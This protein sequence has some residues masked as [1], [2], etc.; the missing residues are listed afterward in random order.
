MSASGKSNITS[1][2]GCID[3]QAKLLVSATKHS[4][5]TNVVVEDGEVYDVELVQIDVSKNID[6]FYNIQLV[7]HEEPGHADEF[8]VFCK[9]GRTGITLTN[10]F[11][12][13]N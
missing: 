5:T 10:L 12:I 1:Q 13:L 6:K 4:G 7:V 3:A 8:F 2:A 9:W 11:I